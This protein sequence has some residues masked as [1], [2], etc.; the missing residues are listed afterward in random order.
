MGVESV[1]GRGQVRLL[2]RRRACF[3]RASPAMRA[4]GTS[5][6]RWRAI[7][8]RQHGKLKANNCGT[9]NCH[10][11]NFFL[12]RFFGLLRVT[13]EADLRHDAQRRTNPY[14]VT[15][16]VAILALTRGYGLS[17][18]PL[19]VPYYSPAPVRCLTWSTWTSSRTSSSIFAGNPCQIISWN[20]S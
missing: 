3:N 9:Y 19:L 4:A 18:I 13:L 16:I 17:A 8:A 6:H 10:T 5:S 11:H 15:P 1:N 2:S 14:S 7:P 12:K 20:P